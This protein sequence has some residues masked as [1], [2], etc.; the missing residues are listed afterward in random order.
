MGVTTGTTGRA[1][2]PDAA[3]EVP[4]D[5]SGLTVDCGDVVTAVGGEDGVGSAPTPP[6]AADRADAGTDTAVA[7]PA[8][9]PAVGRGPLLAADAVDT[10]AAALP[11]ALPGTR[12]LSYCTSVSR[13]A[14][15][16]SC[17]IPGRHGHSQ[18]ATPG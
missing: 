6:Q 10:A 8:A 9:T 4:Q 1:W 14:P 11:P 17:G 13:T 18:A 12:E 16:T 15:C 2:L 5:A 3:T 7:V